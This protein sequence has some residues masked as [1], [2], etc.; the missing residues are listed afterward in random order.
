M[1]ARICP[2]RFRR[3]NVWLA[4]H[5]LPHGGVRLHGQIAQ[6]TV[7]RRL[8]P[9]PDALQLLHFRRREK[10][11]R[12][13]LRALK[14]ERAQIIAPALPQHRGEIIIAQ[15]LGEHFA[16]DGDV[17]IHELL[18]QIDRVRGNDGLLLFLLRPQHARDEIR[19]RFADA[20]ARLHHEMPALRQRRRYRHRH[21]LLLRAK[22]EIL[23]L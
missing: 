8:R 13:L 23:R 4:A 20:R 16:H 18:L 11:A 14:A 22:L 10:L 19:E 12:L 9:L 3:A 2:A 1:A 15:Q 7:L 5:L 17:L 6:R 21:L